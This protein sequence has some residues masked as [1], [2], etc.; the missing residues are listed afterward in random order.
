[1]VRFTVYTGSMF[2]KGSAMEGASS[3][4]GNTD[5]ASGLGREPR[6]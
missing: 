6:W 1:M 5:R 2:M 3:G 4:S